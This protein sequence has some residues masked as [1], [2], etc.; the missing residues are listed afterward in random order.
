M[1]PW[2]TRLGAMI[3]RH[4]TAVR[5]AS[6]AILASTLTLAVVFG[7]RADTQPVTYYACV[8]TGSGNIQMTTAT[9]ACK[10][11]TTKISWNQVGPQGPQG[12]DGLAGPQGPAGPQGDVGSQ[13][14]AG[15]QGPEGPQGPAG[16][17]NREI[18]SDVVVANAGENVSQVV[19]C[20]E[21]KV[22]VGGGYET[23]FFDDFEVRTSA[24]NAG[25]GWI[26]RA[27]N[28]GNFQANLF[29]LA[30]CVSA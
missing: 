18:V 16:M 24:P 10:S 12:S 19:S 5:V 26:V 3:A 28:H 9:G 30:V 25:T 8:N 7:V 22:A 23:S 14:L 11:S 4:G 2:Y 21:G 15:P 29:I 13:G 6:A 20:P 17:L 1:H 27:T